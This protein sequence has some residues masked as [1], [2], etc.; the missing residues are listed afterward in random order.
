MSANRTVEAFF[1]ECPATGCGLTNA[2]P[3]AV[4]GGTGTRTVLGIRRRR[5]R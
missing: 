5:R 3:A 2:V 1:V 4:R